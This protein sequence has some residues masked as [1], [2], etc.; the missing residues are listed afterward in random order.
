MAV[1]ATPNASSL[2]IKFDCGIDMD[3]NSLM[4]TNTYSPIKSI[5]SNDDIMAVT[6]AIV[7]LQKHNLESVTK[8]DNTSLSE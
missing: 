4:K 8:V 3:G 6:N 1:I 5:A 2:K 7:S